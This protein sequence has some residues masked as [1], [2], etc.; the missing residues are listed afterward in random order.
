MTSLLS[1]LKSGGI[2]PPPT[3]A[4]HSGDP[5]WHFDDSNWRFSTCES[6]QIQAPCEGGGEGGGLGSPL[7]GFFPNTGIS[8]L[9][10][11]PK[12]L[13]IWPCFLLVFSPIKT[14]LPLIL[15][16]LAVR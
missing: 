11:S 14:A 16:I 1:Y 4:S 2:P 15:I 3:P 6:G 9:T 10:I 8:F 13:D 12:S 7:A 5:I